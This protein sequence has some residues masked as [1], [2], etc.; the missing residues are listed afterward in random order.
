[1]TKGN[2][3][4]VGSENPVKVGCVAEVIAEYWPAARAVGV[5][6]DSLV[7]AQP[8]TDDEIF[9][10]ALNRAEQ[11]LRKVDSAQ[12]GVGIE[13][14][15]LDTADGMWAFAWVVIVDAGGRT[16]KGKTGHFLLPEGVA[17]MVREEGVELGEADDRF[18]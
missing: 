13:G 16:G 2:I 18:F 15:I 5:S 12:Y 11:A 8:K 7:S 1:M 10:G 17:R 9:T 4:A 6:T 3:F 14:G